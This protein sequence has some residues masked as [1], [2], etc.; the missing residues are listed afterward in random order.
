MRKLVLVSM[1]L[2]YSI[3]AFATRYMDDMTDDR[4]DDPVNYTF[5]RIAITVAAWLVPALILMRMDKQMWAGL[6]VMF[7][8][9]GLIGFA[10]C[11]HILTR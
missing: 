6:W 9:P 2:L 10:G 7:L 5:T 4:Y 8:F 3:P 11:V 1:A